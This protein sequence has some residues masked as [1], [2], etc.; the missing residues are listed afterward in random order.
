MA[1]TPLIA[2]ITAKIK[3]LSTSR[4]G[5]TEALPA[6]EYRGTISTRGQHFSFRCLLPDG[7]GLG[8]GESCTV[9]IEFGYPDLA[10]PIFR[11]NGEFNLW[12]GGI[13]G[14]GRVIKVSPR[15]EPR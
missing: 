8:L 10:L 15:A 3:L 7:A 2:D 1:T 11:A 12:E 6:G 14:Y 4:G 9:D 13:I 5:R